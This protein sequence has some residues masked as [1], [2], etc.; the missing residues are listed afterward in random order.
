MDPYYS[1][2]TTGY[3]SKYGSN[4]AKYEIWEISTMQICYKGFRQSI[5]MLHLIHYTRIYIK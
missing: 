4:H 3:G 1:D 5:Q 2:L